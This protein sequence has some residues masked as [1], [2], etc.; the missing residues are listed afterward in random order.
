MTTQQ[1]QVNATLSTFNQD[2]EAVEFFLAP[3]LTGC[4][5]GIVISHEEPTYC[6]TW[7]NFVKDY[8]EFAHLTPP[9]TFHEQNE[10][11]DDDLSWGV[12]TESEE[13]EY[14][15]QLD[16]YIA[17]ITEQDGNCDEF[18]GLW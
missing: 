5:G 7:E 12:I 1:L 6:K 18:G 15:R 11:G 10:S 2:G 14:Q 4:F 9:P 17:N 16:L 3:D 13:K 8:T